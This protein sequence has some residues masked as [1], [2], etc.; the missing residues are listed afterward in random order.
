VKESTSNK[1]TCST[2]ATTLLTFALT[3]LVAAQAGEADVT[4]VDIT[5]LGDNS[6]R[7]D[8]TVLHEDSGWDHYANRWD[9]LSPDGTVLGSRVLAHPHEQEQPFTRSLTLTIPSDVKEI[10]IQAHDLVHELG[11]ATMTIAVPQ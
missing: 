7:I 8:T 6:Y 3:G 5:A 4:R 9:V 10:T 11:G 2:I 1:K